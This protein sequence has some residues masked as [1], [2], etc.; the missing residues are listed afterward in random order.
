MTRIWLREE[1]EAAAKV[2]GSSVDAAALVVLSELDISS[3]KGEQRRALKTSSNSR[4]SL[5]GV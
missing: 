5:A 1:Q 3:S 4:L 2:G